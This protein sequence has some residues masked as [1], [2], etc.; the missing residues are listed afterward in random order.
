MLTLF[1]EGTE[2]RLLDFWNHVIQFPIEK[3]QNENHFFCN[4]EK[5][6]F[7]FQVVS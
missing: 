1:I 5:G 6:T 2:S 7:S 4:N 3:A